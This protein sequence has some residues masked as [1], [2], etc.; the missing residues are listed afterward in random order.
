[1]PRTKKELQVFLVFT[2]IIRKYFE[3]E[4]KGCYTLENLLFK[5]NISWSE[6]LEWEKEFKNKKWFQNA[7]M[8]FKTIIKENIL[9][10]A[11][12]LGAEIVKILLEDQKEEK[13]LTI[14]EYVEI[15]RNG[16]SA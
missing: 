15:I 16:I 1:R 14:K 7:L 13:E 4:M 9:N 8:D 5:N 3:G 10:N 12:L 6:F 11:K 2:D